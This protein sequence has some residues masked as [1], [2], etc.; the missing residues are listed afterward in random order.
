MIEDS[1]ARIHLRHLWR[2][3]MPIAE[4]LAVGG[5][6]FLQGLGIPAGTA[7]EARLRFAHLGGDEDDY[8]GA[9]VALPLQDGA[10][11]LVAA[12]GC[13]LTPPRDVARTHSAGSKLLSIVEA[14]PDALDAETLVMIDSLKTT[15]TCTHLSLV[16]EGLGCGAPGM[17]ARV[18]VPRLQVGEARRLPGISSSWAPR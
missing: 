15:V 8:P 11:K 6:E 10:G 4:P 9:A 12:E 1:A 7:V 2:A 18:N 5:R 14:L 17:D 13:R 3:T 16:D